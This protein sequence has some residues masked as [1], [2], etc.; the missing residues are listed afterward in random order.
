MSNSKWYKIIFESLSEK[1]GIQHFVE[2][3]YLNF[4]V[5]ILVLDFSG[6]IVASSVTEELKVDRDR[7]YKTGDSILVSDLKKQ[8]RECEDNPEILVDEGVYIINEPIMR[9]GG[10][11]GY[12]VM[13]FYQREKAE[14]FLV[15]NK[16][17]AQAAEVEWSERG[18]IVYY[19]KTME[20]LLYARMVFEDGDY[21]D[22][23]L[24]EMLPPGYYLCL[25]EELDVREMQKAYKEI[26]EWRSDPLVWAEDGY[27]YL[28]FWGVKRQ[29]EETLACE[30]KRV[31]GEK[32]RVA[33]SEYFTA[34]DICAAK[35]EILKRMFTVGEGGMLTEKEYYAR[36]IY[37]CA[38]DILGKD[39]YKNFRM[40]RL[41][42]EE[43]WTLKTFLQSGNQLKKTAAAL[44]IH[45]NTLVYRLMKIQE[46]LQLNINDVKT[47]RALL[48]ELMIY[49]IYQENTLEK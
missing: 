5:S 37:S 36:V 25:L 32:G 39:I 7:E 47:S 46:V 8:R 6:K 27:L 29:A 22:A 18:V 14:E 35:K 40:Y 41:K 11:I 13:L 45:R 30:V 15:L 28:L 24:E 16:I 38:A 3:L 23:G 1:K 21:V 10:I 4:H 20:E 49:E 31:S 48:A 17:L 34:I 12:T 2:Q 44:N 19:G 42:D 26:R 9:K 33:F 43:R